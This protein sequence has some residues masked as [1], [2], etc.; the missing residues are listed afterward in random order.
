MSRYCTVF[1]ISAFYMADNN[2]SNEK[3]NSGSSW[4]IIMAYRVFYSVTVVKSK[5]IHQNE[6][7]PNLDV[8]FM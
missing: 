6:K 8:D 4:L 1:V 7:K 3:L 2:G 5:Q